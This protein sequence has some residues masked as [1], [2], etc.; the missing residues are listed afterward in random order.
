MPISP[1]FFTQATVYRC[2]T[3]GSLKPIQVFLDSDPAE[4][5]FVCAWTADVASGAPLLLLAG[6]LGLLQ[7]VNCLTGVLEAV[8]IFQLVEC[9]E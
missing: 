1:L 5:F 9:R 4:E 8:S 7:V 2:H 6:K 3:D